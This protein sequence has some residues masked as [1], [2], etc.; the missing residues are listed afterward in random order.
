MWRFQGH[1]LSAITLFCAFWIKQKA[2]GMKFSLNMC[3]GIS[4]ALCKRHFPA[5]PFAFSAVPKRPN[6]CLTIKRRLQ[7]LLWHCSPL[8]ERL[9]IE[10]WERGRQ[11]G[12]KGRW[13]YV[14]VGAHLCTC[15][16]NPH[17]QCGQHYLFHRG[18]VG[19]PEEL[20]LLSEGQ[21]LI[22]V[23]GAHRGWNLQTT[24]SGQSEGNTEA[25]F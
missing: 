4:F 22:L 18:E 3:R 25:G 15:V 13:I 2:A 21:D 19:L 10:G 1:S 16:M 8:R 5:F 12:Q 7:S 20:S 6:W 23:D 9:M 17:L 11:R 14:F 24:N